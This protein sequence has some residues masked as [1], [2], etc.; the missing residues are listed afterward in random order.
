MS[1]ASTFNY[2]INVNWLQVDR[3]LSFEDV[4]RGQK[5]KQNL[6]RDYLVKWCD[7]MYDQCTWERESDLKDAR[8]KIEQFARHF[9]RWKKRPINAAKKD[10]YNPKPHLFSPYTI[11]PE[12]LN[13]GTLHPYQLDGL[14]WL[15]HSWYSVCLS[16]CLL[17]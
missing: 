11:Q 15:R 1:D 17:H 13:G 3:I 4:V 7:L 8:D 5:N 9:T 16:V 10:D 2:G 6:E 14:N 12:I